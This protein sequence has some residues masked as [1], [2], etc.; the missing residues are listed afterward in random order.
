MKIE[1][2]MYEIVIKFIE[3]RDLTGLRETVVIKLGTVSYNNGI[4]EFRIT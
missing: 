3:K 1:K 2:Q 4:L